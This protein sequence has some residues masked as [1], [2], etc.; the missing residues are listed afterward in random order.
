MEPRVT[1]STSKVDFHNVLLEGEG[2][3]ETIYLCN[4]E[5]IPFNFNFDKAALLSLE[6]TLGPML[7]I[8]PRSGK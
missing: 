6:G 1:F 3:R 8:H 7:E 2:G 4:E 5:N